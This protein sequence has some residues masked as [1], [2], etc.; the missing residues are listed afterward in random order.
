MAED[1]NRLPVN[2]NKANGMDLFQ[3]SE[4]ENIYRYIEMSD[5]TASALF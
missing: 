1:T 3:K 5:D 2:V 4:A